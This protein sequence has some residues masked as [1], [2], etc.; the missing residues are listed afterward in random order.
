M[1]LKNLENKIWE[2]KAFFEAELP[3]Y[4]LEKFEAKLN[5]HT[6]NLKKSKQFV[7]KSYRAFAV[8][9]SV[10]ILLMISVFSVLELS[11]DLNTPQLSEELM[12]VK[13]YYEQET[14]EKMDEIMLC[15]TQSVEN[16]MLMESTSNRLKKLDA[17]T[18]KLEEKL[19]I[20]NDNQQLKSAYIQSLKAK[21]DV[22]EQMYA[23]I[24]KEQTNNQVTQ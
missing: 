20:A 12:H 7:F 21:S 11:K 5:Q 13:M 18:Q 19:S 22:V 4:D 14:E 23:Q 16:E 24:C 2:N 9:A 15:G 10:S 8:A 17:N 3:T 1:G 6:T